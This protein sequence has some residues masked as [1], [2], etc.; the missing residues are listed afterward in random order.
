MFT[1]VTEDKLNYYLC[2]LSK[3]FHSI[4][5]VSVEQTQTKSNLFLGAEVLPVSCDFGWLRYIFGVI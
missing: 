5:V 4:A 2:L 1:C 3:W